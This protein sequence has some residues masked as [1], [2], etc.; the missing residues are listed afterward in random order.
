MT[1]CERIFCLLN[2]KGKTAY[3]LSKALGV[4]TC[5]TTTWKNKNT[6]PPAKY[7]MPIANFLEVTPDYL[8]TGVDPDSMKLSALEMDML[9]M[10]DHLPPGEKR[11]FNDRMRNC[12]AEQDGVKTVQKIPTTL[13][14]KISLAIEHAHFKQSDIRTVFDVTRQNISQRLQRDGFNEFDAKRIAQFLG[15]QFVSIF[16]FPGGRVYNDETSSNAQLVEKI[17]A[18]KS[19]TE[20]A[21]AKMLHITKPVFHKNLVNNSLKMD[22][23]E[24]LADALGG[25]YECY[26]EFPDGTRI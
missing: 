22:S 8:L 24:K 18:D 14:Q 7:I 21:A 11:Q 15:C 6:D 1:I 3:Q 4:G 5:Q 13:S 2:E 16:T 25:K 23:L 9:E 26:F 20:S 10:F 19:V 12:L 17:L